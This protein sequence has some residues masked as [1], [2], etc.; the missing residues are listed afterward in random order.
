M[1]PKITY[2]A[3][4]RKILKDAVEKIDSTISNE[5]GAI[6]HT[7][8]ANSDCLIHATLGTKNK[9]NVY[10]MDSHENIRKFLFKIV[11]SFS[12]TDMDDANVSEE[13]K[14]LINEL[15]R[16]TLQHTS[17]KQDQKDW[18]TYYRDT[19]CNF[20]KKSQKNR[21]LNDSE[22]K[23]LAILANAYILN[24]TRDDDN[25]IL[26]GRNVFSPDPELRDLLI[27]HI[28]SKK[29]EIPKAISDCDNMPIR[30]I[31]IENSNNIHFSRVQWNKDQMND[32]ISVPA[33]DEAVNLYNTKL[34]HKPDVG[35]NNRAAG[36]I[37]PSEAESPKPA[38]AN[39]PANPPKEPEKPKVTPNPVK[40]V[41]LNNQVYV[42]VEA[43]SVVWSD[44][45]KKKIYRNNI[46]FLLHMMAQNEE[47]KNQF[48]AQLNATPMNGSIVCR[49]AGKAQFFYTKIQVHSATDIAALLIE[50][51]ES[52]EGLKAV[53]AHSSP[54]LK[55]Y[56]DL[57]T[58]VKS[59]EDQADVLDN[60]LTE[61]FKSHAFVR[62]QD[63]QD[64]I[65]TKIRTTVQPDPTHAPISMLHR[66]GSQ[67]KTQG[68]QYHMVGLGNLK[69]AAQWINEDMPKIQHVLKRDSQQYRLYLSQDPK[70]PDRYQI[71]KCEVDAQGEYKKN[72]NQVA[73]TPEEEALWAKEIEGVFKG[74][75]AYKNIH[76]FTGGFKPK[77]N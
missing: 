34:S 68:T 33:V 8:G 1:A 6:H 75:S 65:Q 27:A 51:I 26:K 5:Y 36:P 38:Q 23:L 18:L 74:Y 35:A 22:A 43:T 61:S 62:T 31:H 39:K 25:L 73:I 54:L 40:G 77:P 48:M 20:D 64:Y 71:F 16:V 55:Q 24:W 69:A 76:L 50:N 41:E 12:D 21:F 28:K 3:E 46:N 10:F 70:H 19:L 45:E 56:Q 32:S 37:R 14:N 13:L 58:A 4:D 67:S 29:I 53:K 52:Y 11:T 9:K 59:A 66:K 42:E 17:K 2:T 57:K 63:K 7:S 72:V 49:G 15:A 47:I 30:A 44:D 60:A